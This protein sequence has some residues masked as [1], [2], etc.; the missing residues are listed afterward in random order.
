MSLRDAAANHCERQLLSLL[1]PG[2]VP[3]R[4]LLRSDFELTSAMNG[5]LSSRACNAEI[6]SPSR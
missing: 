3:D 5:R 4:W 2:C 6:D 1:A